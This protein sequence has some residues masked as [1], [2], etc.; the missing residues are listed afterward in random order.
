MKL[1]WICKWISDQNCN[2]NFNQHWSAKWVSDQN[3]NQNFNLYWNLEDEEDDAI[4]TDEVEIVSDFESSPYWSGDALSITTGGEALASNAALLTGSDA[5]KSVAARSRAHWS[6]TPLLRGEEAGQGLAQPPLRGEEAHWSLALPLSTPRT[7]LAGTRAEALFRMA[8]TP[9]KTTVVSGAEP[10]V[11][12]SAASVRLSVTVKRTHV[13]GPT[14]PPMVTTVVTTLP[15]QEPTWWQTNLHC[16]NQEPTWSS[17]ILCNHRYHNHRNINQ[18]FG[19]E[20]AVTIHIRQSTLRDGI[21][22]SL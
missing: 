20:T 1:L 8:P 9:L 19:N 15:S 18:Q 17:F 14:P 5:R 12:D 16:T 11:T 22:V 4:V 7:T 3:C 6:N 13:N 21:C 10:V 2:Q